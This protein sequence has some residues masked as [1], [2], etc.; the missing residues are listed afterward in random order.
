MPPSV[1]KEARKLAFARG[2]S[3]S[4]FVTGLIVREL[5]ATK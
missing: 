2:V 5:E 3:F 1:I 4:A